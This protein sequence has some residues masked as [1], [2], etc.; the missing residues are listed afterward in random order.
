MTFEE[1][2]SSLGNEDSS[3]DGEKKPEDDNASFSMDEQ[4]SDTVNEENKPVDDMVVED[5]QNTDNTMSEGEED[6]PV[7]ED[8]KNT[9]YSNE[10][11]R[12][13]LSDLLNNKK[14]DNPEEFFVVLTNYQDEWGSF[15]NKN[16]NIVQELLEIDTAEA[17]DALC[18]KYNDEL[19]KFQERVAG[20]Y[21]EL[22]F[23]LPQT[24]PHYIELEAGKQMLN[25]IFNLRDKKIEMAV[26]LAME[27]DGWKQF[28]TTNPG[29]LDHLRSTKTEAEAL[30]FIEE[31]NS[32]LLEYVDSYNTDQ[33]NS[34]AEP[35]IT[36][37]QLCNAIYA[38]KKSNNA[39]SLDRV[40]DSLSEEDKSYFNEASHLEELKTVNN[41]SELAAFIAAK[42]PTYIKM[43]SEKILA[44]QQRSVDKLVQLLYNIF[45][46]KED[47][48]ELDKL[49]ASQTGDVASYISTQDGIDM[50]SQVTSFETKQQLNDYIRKN[51]TVVIATEN[52]IDKVTEQVAVPLIPQ[53]VDEKAVFA[54]LKSLWKV[55][56]NTEAMQELEAGLD[57]NIRGF[58]KTTNGEEI[59]ETVLSKQDE[60]GV[61]LYISFLESRVLV[62]SS[63]NER[64]HKDNAGKVEMLLRALEDHYE[65][66]GSAVKQKNVIRST[67]PD[68]EHFINTHKKLI[69]PVLEADSDEGMRSALEALKAA[70]T[71]VDKEEAAALFSEVSHFSEDMITL[72]KNQ[73]AHVV[74]A[75]G[76]EAKN[77]PKKS[78][79]YIGSHGFPIVFT[80]ASKD[81]AATISYS[82][83]GPIGSATTQ[84][85]GDAGAV[86]VLDEAASAEDENKGHAYQDLKAGTDMLN[87]IKMFKHT[88]S[89]SMI[90]GDKDAMRSFW[91]LTKANA[92]DCEGY[93]ADDKDERWLKDRLDTIKS[94]FPVKMPKPKP[95][96]KKEQSNTSSPSLGM[97]GG[98]R[99]EEEES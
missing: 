75:L 22:T 49:I 51:L 64:I 87:I 69:S 82:R 24:T 19:K 54:Y 91:A 67:H 9:D 18:A 10:I 5:E 78:C 52:L 42:T 44:G 71:G 93:E 97:G 20:G 99:D 63:G 96:P 68:I 21:Y 3:I 60:A 48:Q 39:M 6:S 84:Y 55:K 12:E 25:K 11:F 33:L 26:A 77:I 13:I 36:F 95:A 46:L 28:I 4:S 57:L 14:D 34:L 27:D 40:L 86:E 80:P 50:I 45:E 53:T 41:E 58:L 37:S 70:L 23:D 32:F 8:E 59:T 74:V 17:L 73:W 30:K 89:I 2:K 61:N 29:I 81:S 90:A 56:D 94:T 83:S 85:S 65:A 66:K 38:A 47:N 15:F 79:T 1:E 92:I 16:M 98:S 31:N 72:I 88:G 35:N 62:H 43:F 7:E 76:G